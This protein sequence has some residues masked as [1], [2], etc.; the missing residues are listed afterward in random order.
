MG[1][2]RADPD[3]IGVRHIQADH[4]RGV[5]EDQLEVGCADV[6]R[7]AEN[8]DDLAVVVPGCGDLPR[9]LV[10]DAG[11][12]VVLQVRTDCGQVE[13]HIDACRAKM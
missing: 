11:Q 1:L 5:D 6:G 13:H 12:R 3:Q 4:D 7:G 9:R 8:A 10:D 2:D